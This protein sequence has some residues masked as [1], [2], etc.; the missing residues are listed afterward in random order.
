M[1][2]LVNLINQVYP[3][4]CAC[5]YSDSFRYIS[6]FGQERKRQGECV[7]E[8]T[9]TWLSWDLLCHERA[10]VSQTRPR[11][12]ITLLSCCQMDWFKSLNTDKSNTL[13]ALDDWIL[14]LYTINHI[15]AL[16]IWHRIKPEG[17]RPRRAL[18]LSAI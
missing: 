10:Y 15:L 18:T 5:Q 16:N 3:T 2:V 9:F 1:V 11:F 12:S 4:L 13:P 17:G 14:Q 7:H 8:D 6:P